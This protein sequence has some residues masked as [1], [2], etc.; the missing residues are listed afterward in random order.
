LK[1][2]WR[3]FRFVAT[4][5]AKLVGNLCGARTQSGKSGTETCPSTRWPRVRKSPASG[6]DRRT[7]LPAATTT[8]TTHDKTSTPRFANHLISALEI[9]LGNIWDEKNH[10]NLIPWNFRG[11]VLYRVHMMIQWSKQPFAATRFPA[12]LH[13][14]YPILHIFNLYQQQPMVGF[15]IQNYR[16]PDASHIMRGG[17]L[18]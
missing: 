11:L 4:L 1:E 16:W 10:F 9:T 5:Q 8:T 6:P 12:Q 18:L 3:A 7:T 15:L 17:P 13:D 2:T 14:T